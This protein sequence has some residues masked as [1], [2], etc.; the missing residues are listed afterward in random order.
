MR[1]SLLFVAFAALAINLVRA[2]THCSGDNYVEDYSSMGTYNCA[3][4]AVSCSGS[5]DGSAYHNPGTSCTSSGDDD[6]Q[7][8]NVPG[9]GGSEVQDT[10]Y[11]ATAN[12]VP[13]SFHVDLLSCDCDID[14]PGMTITDDPSGAG[15]QTLYRCTE[16]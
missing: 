8:V 15:P 14:H 7:C 2:T 13:C 9:P 1:Y 5:C 12:N 11:S 4:D 3:G 10:D 6:K 16:T